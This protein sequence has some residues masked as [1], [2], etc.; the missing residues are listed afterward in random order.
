M[1][2]AGIDYESVKD[3]EGVRVVLYLTSCSHE[4]PMCHNPQTHDPQYGVLFTDDIK[5]KIMKA[6]EI[7]YIAGLC[8]SGGD[9]LHQNNL[10]EVLKLVH[11][12]RLSFGESKTIWLYTGYMW[13]EIFPVVDT[14]DFVI[15][16]MLRKEIV[17]YCNVVVDGRYVHELR[18]IILPYRGS[19]N[20]RLIDVKKTLE[21]GRVVKWLSK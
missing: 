20:Q 12:I 10:S 6:L 13:E 15:E 8:L 17:R 5:S 11:D 19:S 2:I 7:P 18:D 16:K 4:C 9:P 3:G 21:E 1:N 14:C